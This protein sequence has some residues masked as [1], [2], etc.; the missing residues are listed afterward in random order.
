MALFD[1]P[2][3]RLREYS[4]RLAEPADFDAFWDR[5]LAQTRSHALDARFTPYDSGLSTVDTYD[6]EFGGWN[7]ERICG[8]LLVPRDTSSPTGCVV[9]YVGYGGG[10]G[11][12]HDRL[13]YSAAGYAHFVMD[14]RGQGGDTA[15]AG[16]SGPHVP[17]FLTDG[18]L[19]PDTF[20]YRRLISDAVRAVE[21][22]RAHPAVDSARVAIAGGSQGGGLTIAVAGLVGD[23]AA[24]LPDVPFLCHYRRA[25]QVTAELPYAE[26]AGFAARHPQRA[27]QMFATL[28]YFDGVHFCARSNA[29]ALFSVALMDQIC[30]PSTVFAAYNNYRASKDIR[31]YEWNEHEG[32]GG[33]HAAARLA[34]LHEVIGTSPAAVR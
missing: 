29:P 4:P 14:T 13:L 19:S 9:E 20:Y 5:T 27:E 33:H 26:L 15:D 32:G 24:V 6:V 23:L 18:V 31:V 34:F 1:Y 21:A 12:V 16:G 7:G 2:L 17:G 8:W 11:L 25:A 10:R 30:P 3:E 22:A 28:G